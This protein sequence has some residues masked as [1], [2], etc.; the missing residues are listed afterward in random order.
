M[1]KEDGWFVDQVEIVK[2][3]PK[4][5]KEKIWVFNIQQWFSLHEADCQI[6]RILYP[7]V[8][9]KTEYEV[10]VV[11]GS[12]KGAG[13]DAN[14]YMTLFGKSG[15]T[16]KLHLKSNKKTAFD[17]GATDVFN[18]KTNCVGQMTKLR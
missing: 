7:K 12:L 5:G 18:L 3:I 9:S 8:A 14:V 2:T 13:T 4:T 11:T 15:Q 17:K 6:S 1:T 10:V 16:P